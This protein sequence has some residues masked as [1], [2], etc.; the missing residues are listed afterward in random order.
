MKLY[1]LAYVSLVTKP[2][3][4]SDLK[5]ILSTS[6]LNNQAAHVTGALCFSRGAF[7]Q[8]LEGERYQIN[9]TVRRIGRDDRHKDIYLIGLEPIEKRTFSNWAMAFIDDTPATQSI[10]F[11]HC[12]ADKLKVDELSLQDAIALATELHGPGA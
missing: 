4:K 9:K 2:L 11:K 10:I 7:L 1:C 6:V 3:T 12:G 8:V 5:Q